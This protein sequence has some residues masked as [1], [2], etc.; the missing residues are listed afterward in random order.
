MK[1]SS[2]IFLFVTA[3]VASPLQEKP[4]KCPKNQVYTECGTACP[5]RCGQ[6]PP[7]ACTMQCV[8]GCQC[9]PGFLLNSSGSC[10]PPSCC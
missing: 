7:E 2:V 10:V 4:T 6:P 1:L 8:I 3:V 9:K 5:L